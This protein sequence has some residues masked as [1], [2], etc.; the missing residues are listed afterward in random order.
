MI[1]IAARSILA[2]IPGGAD[3][4]ALAVAPDQTWMAVT[5]RQEG[6]LSLIDLQTFE[7][8]GTIYVG[9]WPWGVVTDGGRV[10]VALE[11][12]A[13]VAEIDPVAGRVLR[14]MPV[15]EQPAGLALYGDFLY[16]SHL[17]G[18]ALSLLY[19]PTGQVAAAPGTPDSGLSP[20]VWL[21][22]YDGTLYVRPRATTPPTGPDLRHDGVP[23]VNVFRMADMTVSQPA[24]R[25]RRGRRPVSLPFD[26]AFDRARRWLWVVNTGSNDVS[27]IDTTTGLAR[28]N[29]KVGASPRGLTRYSDWSYVFVYNALDGTVS[30]IE[31]AFMEEVD[32]LAATQLGLPIDLLIGAQLFMAARRSPVRGS[33]PELRDVPLRWPER[34]QPGGLSRRT[35]ADADPA[36]VAQTG[37]G[38]RRGSMTSWPTT[39]GWCATSS[40][41]AG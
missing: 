3:P 21:N 6:T 14:L 15:P 2:E 10:Y 25:A 12:Q 13:A 27:V 40:T 41:V 8:T 36:R 11:G 31:M 7:V 20:A 26:V 17:R 30:M 9:L 1:D 24:D 33:P 28:A 38:G 19:L 16:V 5:S 37:P 23:V 34:R 18:G 29:I 39:T 4:R 35:G 22:P 32:E